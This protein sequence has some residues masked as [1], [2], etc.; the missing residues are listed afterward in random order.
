MA[1]VSETTQGGCPLIY[2]SPAGTMVCAEC[3]SGDSRHT[4][5]KW[6]LSEGWR[7]IPHSHG[8]AFP[9]R[10]CGVMIN[11]ATGD[12]E[13]NDDHL[14]WEDEHDIIDELMEEEDERD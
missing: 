6:K 9:C 3:A 14:P 5:N 7:T 11:S 4:G 2:I 12:D 8:A 1:R 10:T 13:W